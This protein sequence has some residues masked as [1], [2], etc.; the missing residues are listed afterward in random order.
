LA[1]IMHAWLINKGNH[2]RMIAA[3]RGRRAPP[4]RAGNHE[5]MIAAGVGRSGR[6]KERP[7]GLRAEGTFLRGPR[8]G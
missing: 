3:G 1:A 5:R 8:V 2:E 7:A 4:R 6:G